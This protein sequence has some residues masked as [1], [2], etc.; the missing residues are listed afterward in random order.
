MHNKTS[1]SLSR[2]SWYA[3]WPH[4]IRRFWNLSNGNVPLKQSLH[5]R[6]L[7]CLQGCSPRIC[8]FDWAFVI[9]PLY[10]SWNKIRKCC[11]SFQS[12]RWSSWSR[13]CKIS[14]TKHYQVLINF[15]FYMIL[16][17]AKFGLDRVRNA[18]HCT[19]LAEDGVVEC[20]YFFNIL[21]DY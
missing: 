9:W 2:I 11:S 6:I 3:N 8:T 7:W 21:Q 5:W 17:R 4:S 20:E 10:C 12:T 14:K 18:I 15:K 1:Y 19:D 13:D 16:Y